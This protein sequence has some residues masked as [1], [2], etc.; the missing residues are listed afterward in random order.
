MY[1]YIYLAIFFFLASYHASENIV[2]SPI[3]QATTECCYNIVCPP[4]LISRNIPWNLVVAFAPRG[5]TAQWQKGNEEREKGSTVATALQGEGKNIFLHLPV[6]AIAR[7]GED[8]L[9]WMS[10]PYTIAVYLRFLP[11]CH[12]NQQ[13][14]F[15]SLASLAR[16]YLPGNHFNVGGHSTVAASEWQIIEVEVKG[17]HYSTLDSWVL[18]LWSSRTWNG[19]L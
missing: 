6:V 14:L 4:F 13:H 11:L 16:S 7:S 3:S 5:L 18:L 1:V 17:V 15:S 2:S 12:H 19:S 9:M 8:I 10:N